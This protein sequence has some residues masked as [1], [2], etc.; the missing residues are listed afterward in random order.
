M[1]KQ[2]AYANANKEETAIERER[3]EKFEKKEQIKIELKRAYEK[4]LQQKA[5]QKDAM[6]ALKEAERKFMEQASNLDRIHGEQLK[7]VRKETLGLAAK[8]NPNNQYHAKPT[9]VSRQPRHI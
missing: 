7:S 4:D 2:L 3:R 6:R 9:G 5:A 1:G 8:G